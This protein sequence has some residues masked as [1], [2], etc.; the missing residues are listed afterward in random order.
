VSGSV[1]MTYRPYLPSDPT[2][3]QM[4]PPLVLVMTE[5]RVTSIEVSGRATFANIVNL[6]YPTQYYDRKRFPGLGG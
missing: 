4:T 5:V 1:E 6:K 2:K 3:P